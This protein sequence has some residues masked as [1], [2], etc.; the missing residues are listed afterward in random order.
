MLALE[1]ALKGLVEAGAPDRALWE[2][3]RDAA[4]AELTAARAEEASARARMASSLA[5]LERVASGTGAAARGRPGYGDDGP[6]IT[7]TPRS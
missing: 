6:V 3:R 4:L 7:I 5:D 2:H 1:A